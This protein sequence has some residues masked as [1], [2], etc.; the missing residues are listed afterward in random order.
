MGFNLDP[1]LPPEFITELSES[2]N[3]G[4]AAA[5]LATLRR[6]LA[7]KE[8]ECEAMADLLRSLSDLVRSRNAQG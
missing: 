2:D 1:D 5:E 4:P 6:K 8:V 3:M 7:A